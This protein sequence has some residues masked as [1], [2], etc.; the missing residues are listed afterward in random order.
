ML[1]T[2]IIQYGRPYREKSFS[3]GLRNDSLIRINNILYMIKNKDWLWITWCCRHFLW[4]SSYEN[5]LSGQTIDNMRWRPPSPSSLKILR[6]N[7]KY[8]SL[9]V[10]KKFFILLKNKQGCSVVESGGGVSFN[11]TECAWRLEEQCFP[12]PQRLFGKKAFFQMWA[13]VSAVFGSQCVFV[14]RVRKRE[15]GRGGLTPVCDVVKVWEHVLLI[16]AER[17]G[18]SGRGQD[19]RFWGK[20]VVEVADVVGVLDGR[21]KRRLHLLG[22]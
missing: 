2:L 5:L 15:K 22:Q 14:Q 1:K 21:H 19:G 13:T 17:P 16:L 3:Y 9:F 4:H 11:G 6:R 18:F 10:K 7:A 8:K 20:F 12:L